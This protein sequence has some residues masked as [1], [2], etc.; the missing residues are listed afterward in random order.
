MNTKKE[1]LLKFHG[2][3]YFNLLKTA[4]GLDV[5]FKKLL[6]DFKLTHQ[7]F[8]ILRILKGSFPKPLSASEIKER[9][10]FKN[11]DVTRLM[12][13]LALKDYIKRETCPSNRRKIDILI[14]QKGLN[15]LDEIAPSAQ[16]FIETFF[17]NKITRDEAKELYRILN[18]INS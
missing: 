10:I 18:K 14:S 13:R 12:D 11:S 15:L 1:N 6:D 4:N 3:A 8:N 16:A 2:A 17:K 7:Q 9:M 5:E